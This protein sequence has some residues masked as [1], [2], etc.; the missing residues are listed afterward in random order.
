MPHRVWRSVPLLV[1]GLLP[2][3]GC[4]GEASEAVLERSTSDAGSWAAPAAPAASGVSEAARLVQ[5]HV[6]R[7]L[8]AADGALFQSLSELRA[9]PNA[10]DAI[11]DSYQKTPA[12]NN[13]KRW[14][15]TNALGFL[16]GPE[17]AAS[18]AEIASAPVPDSASERVR[19]EEIQIR[20]RALAG[21]GRL[22]RSGQLDALAKLRE[23]MTS[24]VFAVRR[25]AAEA[26]VGSPRNPQRVREARAILPPA[27]HWV[28]DDLPPLPHLAPPPKKPAR[29]NTVPFVAA[30]SP[31]PSSAPVGT[32]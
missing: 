11:R 14:L 28:T 6:D 12:E 9:Q 20:F 3:F 13:L 17:A 1:I 5:A 32:P 31:S 4:G 22:A 2:I 21:L 30:P 25:M 19:G 15:L 26:Y 7:G 16:E 24:P 8:S 18:L 27:D 10:A 23:C 29:A